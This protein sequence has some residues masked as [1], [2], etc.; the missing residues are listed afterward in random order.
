M[1]GYEK[2]RQRTRRKI[3]EAATRLFARTGYHDSSISG[4]AR[5]AGTS[6]ATIYNH[7]NSKESLLES[8]VRETLDERWQTFLAM[9][10]SGLSFRQ[11]MEALI[12]EKIAQEHPDSDL[13]R[14]IPLD[15]PA[16]QTILEEYYQQ[17]TIP[18]FREM[19]RQG[20]TEGTLNPDL[21][22]DAVLFYLELFRRSQSHPDFLAPA[23]TELRKGLVHLFFYGLLGQ[24]K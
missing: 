6:P 14:I 11:K 16:V 17:K 2:R 18:M 10:Q 4:I 3:R 19:V 21:S 7:F 1:N 23:N 22:E 12:S 13:L 9:H 5:E 8:V 20:K 24:K 15:V